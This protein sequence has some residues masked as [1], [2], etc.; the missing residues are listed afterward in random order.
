MNSI[1]TDLAY[2]PVL[3]GGNAPAVEKNKKVAQ[4]MESLFLYQLLQEMDRT[5]ERDEEGLMYSEY[6]DTYRSLFNQELSREM[7]R[8]GGIG[9]Q[10]MVERDLSQHHDPYEKQKSNEPVTETALR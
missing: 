2:D 9:I 5:V 4:E 8:A 6:E 3:F 7:A 1:M 10:E